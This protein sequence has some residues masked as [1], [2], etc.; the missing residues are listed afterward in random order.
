MER[1]YY[2]P[3]E[4][5]TTISFFSYISDIRLS[6]GISHYRTTFAGTRLWQRH[7]VDCLRLRPADKNT[8]CYNRTS[9]SGTRPGRNLSFSSRNKTYQLLLQYSQLSLLIDL[10]IHI[11]DDMARLVVS[12]LQR[13]KI[14]PIAMNHCV[15]NSYPSDQDKKG[16]DFWPHQG[17]F[18]RWMR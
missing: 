8:T 2:R 7:F 17:S 6:N 5:L 9:L 13:K 4:T 16:G 12:I 15:V 18:A 1:V 11:M 10:Y 14:P 3:P